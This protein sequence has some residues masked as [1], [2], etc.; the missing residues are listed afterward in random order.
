MP[1]ID[2]P[3]A[4]RRLCLSCPESEEVRSHGMSTFRV[5]GGKTFAMYAVNHHGD[6]RIALWLNVSA[7][8]QDAYLRQ[9]SKHFFVPPYVG[10]RGWLGVRLDLGIPWKQAIHLVRLAYQYVAPARLR[11]L[12]GAGPEPPAPARRL[13]VAEIDP[14]NTP[15]GKRV[16]ASMRKICLTLPETS[17][18]AQF[19]QPVWRVGKRVFA[20]ASCHDG[21][22][23]VDFW[24]GVPAQALMTR[25]PRFEIP[26]YTG[27][28][29]WISLDV[30]NGHREQELRALAIESYRHFALKRMLARLAV[31]A[32]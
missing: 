20:Q 27:H 32:E 21:H 19:G 31:E 2:L 11:D 5:R 18:G 22:W 4:V 10:P 17:E 25:D 29:G 16:L 3:E 8:A 9:G 23:R 6:G 12:A 14:K 26:R 15:R 13:T 28:D 30:S 7:G 1:E 24:V